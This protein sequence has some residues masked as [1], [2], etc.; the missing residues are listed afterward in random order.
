MGDKNIIWFDIPVD[1]VAFVKIGH[2]AKHFEKD[3]SY[4]IDFANLVG[5]ALTDSCLSRA[6]F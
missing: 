5:D 6:L 2:C 4:I 3:L 1:D